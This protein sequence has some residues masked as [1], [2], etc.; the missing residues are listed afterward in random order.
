MVVFTNKP[1]KVPDE[2]KN[3]IPCNLNAV[4]QESCNF[5]GGVY[6]IG[7]HTECPHCGGAIPPHHYVKDPQGNIIQIM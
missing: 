5:C 7:I 1:R 3:A 6:I 2:Y 4:Y